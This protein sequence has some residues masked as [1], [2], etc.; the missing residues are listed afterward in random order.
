[1]HEGDAQMHETG[2]TLTFVAF[3]GWL[4]E[5]LIDHLKKWLEPD[6]LLSVAHSWD[7]GQECHIA[8]AI[9]D[10]FHLLPPPAVKFLETG[11]RPPAAGL[12]WWHVWLLQHSLPPSATISR[13]TSYGRGS[14]RHQECAEY[15]L[16]RHITMRS[17]LC[18]VRGVRFGD[19]MC[20]KHVSEGCEEMVCRRSIDW[21][22]A[23]CACRS[24]RAWWC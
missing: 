10:L 24:G 9:L 20:C 19:K 4:G 1:M 2:F 3:P 8:A 11:V 6:K 22:A 5:K 14:C 23:V 13:N 18:R 15:T 17:H 12:P 7:P 21:C 16:A